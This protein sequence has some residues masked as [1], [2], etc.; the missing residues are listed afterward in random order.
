MK[1]G[2]RI[3]Q[4]DINIIFPIIGGLANFISRFMISKTDLSKHPIILSIGS[5]F[6]MSLSLILFII[7]HFKNKSNNKKEINNKKNKIKLFEKKFK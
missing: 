7:Y 4:I 5:T 2:I 3:G 1:C 6:G